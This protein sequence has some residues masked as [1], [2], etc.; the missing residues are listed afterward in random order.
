VDDERRLHGLLAHQG[1]SL[2]PRTCSPRQRRTKRVPADAAVQPS[3]RRGFE[4]RWLADQPRCARLDGRAGGLRR[5]SLWRG[6]GTVDTSGDSWRPRGSPWVG[7]VQSVR[8]PACGRK[9][10]VLS[11]GAVPVTLPP[12]QDGHPRSF[13]PQSSRKAVQ[14]CPS[15]F[16]LF[17]PRIPPA[18]P[19]PLTSSFSVARIGARPGS[20]C[21]PARIVV[22]VFAG[23]PLL[24][25]EMPPQVLRDALD[26]VP[27]FELG[28][29]LLP[30]AAPA[31]DQPEQ[32]AGDRAGVVRFPALVDGQEQA[33]TDLLI[34]EA[35]VG[36][37]PCGESGRPM[38]SPRWAVGDSEE[39]A[40]A[41]AP[42]NK[43][44][45]V[46]PRTRAGRQPASV[47]A[48]AMWTRPHARTRGSSVAF[49]FGR[50]RIGLPPFLRCG[51]QRP[52]RVA[53]RWHPRIRQRGKTWAR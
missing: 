12:G 11:A 31:V 4:Q 20:S 15:H 2:A 41:P 14:S 23:P 51:S 29:P 6:F 42:R 36:L 32:V 33:V 49:R 27:E 5:G 21:S 35:L 38:V 16:G 44:P 46:T 24:R 17:A 13:N 48:R 8:A 50:G 43:A 39:S 37:G 28:K 3:S 40:R 25:P 18:R 10:L 7:S 47:H 30:D 1:D 34:W 9:R 45:P 26:D 19:A 22:E 53:A 52:R